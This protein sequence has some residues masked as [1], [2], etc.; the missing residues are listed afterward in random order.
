MAKVRKISKF[1][2]KHKWDAN[3]AKNQENTSVGEIPKVN[4]FSYICQGISLINNGFFRWQFINTHSTLE[5]PQSM[6]ILDFFLCN[7]IVTDL[8]ICLKC[9]TPKQRS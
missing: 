1:K 8:K 4:W 7:N 6:D 5:F 9:L 2:I 3:T